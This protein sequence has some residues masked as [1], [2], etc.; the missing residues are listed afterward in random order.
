MSSTSYSRRAVAPL[1]SRSHCDAAQDRI[2]LHT[3]IDE[4]SAA[5]L[6]LGISKTSRKPV[7]VVT[8][9]GTATANLHPAILEAH[10][11]GVR[12][13]AL[14]ADRPASLRGTNANQ[15]TNQ[16]HLY[17]DAVR[18]FADVAEAAEA[19][20]FLAEALVEQGPSHLNLQFEEPLVP[21][22]GRAATRAQAS[23]RVETQAT[24]PLTW[25]SKR[26]VV[27]AGD[28]AGM[29]ARVLAEQ[30]GW[31]LFAEPTSGS[32]T[33]DYAIR[34]YRLLLTRFAG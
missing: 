10:H 6:A 30:N 33:G 15:T 24:E 1:R 18:H 5:F 32:R 17:G 25:D 27:V 19:V 2:T 11:A 7:A 28:D 9:S 12:L 22:G 26:T 31:P 23:E 20:A 4:R 13:I 16:V 8:T 29:R 21:D 34:T 3:R 14:T